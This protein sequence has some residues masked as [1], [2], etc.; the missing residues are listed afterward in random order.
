MLLQAVPVATRELLESPS[1]EHRVEF[2]VQ[3]RGEVPLL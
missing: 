2:K 3:G 1:L